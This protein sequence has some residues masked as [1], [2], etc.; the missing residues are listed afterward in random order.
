MCSAFGMTMLLIKTLMGKS[1]AGISLK[2]LQCYTV[3]FFFRLLSIIWHE[4]YL[5]FDRSGDFVY[6]FVE[7]CSLVMCIVSI[8]L[9]T[10][11]YKET[12][13]LNDDSFGN[14]KIPSEFGAL[15]LIVPSLILAVL[16]HPKLNNVWWSDICWTFALYTEAVAVLPQLFMFQKAGGVVE[17]YTSHYVFSL[18]FA[19]LLQL[20]FWLSSYHELSDKNSWSFVGIFV[21]VAQALQMLLMADFFYF[22]ISSVRKGT[23]MMLPINNV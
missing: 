9:I 1:S 10:G 18:G 20:W 22:Y 14:L 5:P 4:G 7:F 15:Y 2:S 6:Q 13:R 11:K 16:I 8:V 23:P 12:Y 17:A 3:V 21:L 19:R